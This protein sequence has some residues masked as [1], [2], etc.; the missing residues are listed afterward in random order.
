ME[1]YLEIMN[2][3][4][5]RSQMK[6]LNEEC[7]EF[8]EAV[9]NFEDFD[10]FFSKKE[11]IDVVNMLQAREFVIEEFADMLILLSQFAARYRIK[12]EEISKAM[13]DKLDRTLDRIRTGYYDDEEDE[14]IS[15]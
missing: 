12:Q 4:G 8:L 6:K 13:D 15:K 10:L 7:F 2:H 3:F 5:Y 1:K 9:D 11:D 14:N